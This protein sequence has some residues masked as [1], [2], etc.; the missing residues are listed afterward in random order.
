MDQARTQQQALAC[1]PGL[2]WS[3]L[4][5]KGATLCPQRPN[6]LS[7][8]LVRCILK[9]GS[10]KGRTRDMHAFRSFVL[11]RWTPL[12]CIWACTFVKYWS[13]DY[14]RSDLPGWRIVVSLGHDH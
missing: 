8:S 3:G 11:G 10:E 7:V 2:V 13:L 12:R 6:C 5:K 1:S 4:A 14:H 9:A